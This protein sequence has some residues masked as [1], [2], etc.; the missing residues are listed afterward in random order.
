M[1]ARLFVGLLFTLYSKPSC[2]LAIVYKPL[3]ALKRSGLTVDPQTMKA[4]LASGLLIIGDLSIKMIATPFLV[5]LAG[6]P[7]MPHSNSFA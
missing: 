4:C 6:P 5:S 1:K 7:D 3:R 2:N